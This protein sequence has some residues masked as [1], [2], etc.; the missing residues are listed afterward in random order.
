[1]CPGGGF[2][3]L[4]KLR[5]VLHSV[6]ISG[7]EETP[8]SLLRTWT[9]SCAQE[10]FSDT[11]GSSSSVQGERCSSQVDHEAGLEEAG[12]TGPGVCTRT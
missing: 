2:C 11:H 1:M 9:Q 6:D 10:A 7:W 8:K 5:S 4:G 3:F 12:C